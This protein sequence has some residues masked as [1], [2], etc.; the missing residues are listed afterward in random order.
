M[1]VDKKAIDFHEA[2]A[3]A[4]KLASLFSSAVDVLGAAIEAQ[5]T[6]RGKQT[7]RSTNLFLRSRCAKTN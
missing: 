7:R 1:A 2:L 5:A 4:K 6:I 3:E